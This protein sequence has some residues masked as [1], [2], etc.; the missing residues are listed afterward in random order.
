MLSHDN[1]SL[2]GA[3]R[4]KAAT[5]K[6]KTKAEYLIPLWEILRESTYTDRSVTLYVQRS[7]SITD[8]VNQV[9]SITGFVNQ[10]LS[11]RFCQSQVWPIRSIRAFDIATPLRCATKQMNLGSKLWGLSKG[12][13]G[14]IVVR[15]R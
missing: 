11:I 8:F 3:H 1:G 6:K 14:H 12:L 5:E 13:L 4:H 15:H 9:L 10:V 2:R 7:L